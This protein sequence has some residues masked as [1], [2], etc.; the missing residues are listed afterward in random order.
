MSEYG[1]DNEGQPMSVSYHVQNRFGKK[2]RK[3]YSFYNTKLTRV[4]LKKIISNCRNQFFL[5]DLEFTI[6]SFIEYFYT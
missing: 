2:K 3:K 5:K 4:P 6:V 1:I